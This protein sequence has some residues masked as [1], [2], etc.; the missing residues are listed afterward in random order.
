[1]VKKYLR[2]HKLVW[3]V[4]SKQSITESFNST[5]PFIVTIGKSTVIREIE[6]KDIP[7]MAKLHCDVFSKPPWKELWEQ[8]WAQERL[9]WLYSLP[10]ARGYVWEEAGQIAGV[11]MGHGTPFKG[12]MKFDIVELFVADDQ[13]QQGIG[14]ALVNKLEEDLAKDGYE[15]TKLLTLTDSG[16]E[17]F[18]ESL[19]FQ[20]HESLR[21]FSHEL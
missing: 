21:F 10:Y 11:I 5:F 1:M 7:G 2:G 6:K 9:E 20:C 19:G 17:V 4:V 14:R 18:Y 13:Q 12:R 15:Y 8:Q 16:P 3:N